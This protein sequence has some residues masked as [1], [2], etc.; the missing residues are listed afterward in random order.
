MP[1]DPDKNDLLSSAHDRARRLCETLQRQEADLAADKVLE[2]AVREAGLRAVRSAAACAG[3][4]L[5]LAEQALA[6]ST[7]SGQSPGAGSGSSS[8]FHHRDPA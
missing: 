7:G 4:L 3:R 2:P 5:A 6:P 8:E 1:K